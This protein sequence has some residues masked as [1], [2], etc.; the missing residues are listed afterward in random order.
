MT[1]IGVRNLGES[2]VGR[3]ITVNNTLSLWLPGSKLLTKLATV[4]KML[5]VGGII[6]LKVDFNVVR[7]NVLYK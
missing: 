6:Y 1:E 3:T 2:N 4:P 7:I 5:S